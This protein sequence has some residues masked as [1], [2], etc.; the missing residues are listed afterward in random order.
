MQISEV[1]KKTLQYFKTSKEALTPEN[2]RVAFCKEAKKLG[3]NLPECNIIEHS[4][5]RLENPLR[6]Y[7][8]EYPIKTTDELISFFIAQINRLALVKANDTSLLFMQLLEEMFAIL[9]MLAIENISNEAC[10]TAKRDLTHPLILQDEIKRWR[11]IK[12]NLKIQRTDGK[13]ELDMAARE[14]SNIAH[15]LKQN[16]SDQEKSDH[17]IG[18]ESQKITIEF[19][20]ENINLPTSIKQL[21]YNFNQSLS[22]RLATTEMMKSRIA[23]LESELIKMRNEAQEDYVTKVLNRRAM[24]ELI[25]LAEQSYISDRRDYAIVMFSIDEFESLNDELGLRSSDMI[26]NIVAQSLKNGLPK[27]MILGHFAGS[28]FICLSTKESMADL[29]DQAEDMI[30]KMSE[31]KFV[32]ESLMFYVTLSCGISLRHKYN[33]MDQTIMAADRYLRSAKSE[34]GNQLKFEE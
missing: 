34:G 29:Q 14:L 25:D 8:L 18:A 15:E 28:V 3:L 11:S 4:L 33:S 30:K 22:Q 12:N 10:A 26:L 9:E 5:N 1:I 23:V 27:D 16:L 2:Y 32:Y 13:K 20:R 24:S 21:F 19:A 17:E 7:A 6:K 31:K